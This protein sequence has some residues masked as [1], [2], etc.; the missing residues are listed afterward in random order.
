[1]SL[2]LKKTQIAEL[3]KEYY[4]KETVRNEFFFFFSF[5]I[6]RRAEFDLI[7][8]ASARLKSDEC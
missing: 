6:F 1:M 5:C 7:D 2:V 3:R 8:F 4:F